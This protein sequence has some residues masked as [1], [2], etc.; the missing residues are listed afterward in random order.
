M[1]SEA[2][3]P[4]L[5]V[6]N[7][8]KRFSRTPDLSAKIAQRLGA[9]SRE[10]I[11][12]AVDNIS[13]DIQEGEVFGLVGESGCGKSTLGRVIAGIHPPTEGE[14]YYQS[15][16]IIELDRQHKTDI[17]M[18]F[19][20]P[21]SSLNPRMRVK[22][23]VA[24]GLVAKGMRSRK[25]RSAIVADCLR[26]VGLD[27]SYMNR[28][29]H[30]FSGGQRQ[31]ISIAR[32]LAVQ[33]KLLVCDESIAALDVSIQAQVINLFMELR[34]TFKLTYIFISHDIGVVQHISDRV[35]VMYLG[36]IVELGRASE[37]FRNPQHPYT[38]ALLDA[39]P[40]LEAKRRAFKPVEGEIPSPL[41]PPSGC[42]F[43]K[44]C[45]WVQDICRQ[46]VPTLDSVST[47]HASACHF[48]P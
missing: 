46:T 18:I 35:G 9:A 2:R 27:P 15:R 41:D 24:E 12:Y 8:S 6:Q 5:A 14:V 3:K 11:V 45:P 29:P 40:V 28:Y 38:R 30:Q 32:A 4:I 21:Q 16:N 37:L 25:E 22:D 42:H 48:N 43:H 33:P 13:L 17:Q 7:V 23:I 36:R 19:Q 44:R 26:N 47:E 39:I 34:E 10:E 1:M 20:D 31:R